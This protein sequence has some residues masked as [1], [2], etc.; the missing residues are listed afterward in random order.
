MYNMQPSLPLKSI[1]H[2]LTIDTQHF[3]CLIPF[4]ANKWHDYDNAFIGSM[5]TTWLKSEMEMV[6]AP[7]P[8]NLFNLLSSN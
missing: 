1:F 8:F 6:Y 7:I 5:S 4:L 2:H 3:Y